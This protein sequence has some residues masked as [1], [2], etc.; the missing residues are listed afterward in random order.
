MEA[1]QI[2]NIL[3][4]THIKLSNDPSLDSSLDNRMT[5]DKKY[6]PYCRIIL[7]QQDLENAFFIFHMS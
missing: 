7:A 6:P 2:K 4:K 3:I 1:V 5:I